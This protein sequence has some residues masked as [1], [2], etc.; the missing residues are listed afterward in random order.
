[1]KLPGQGTKEAGWLQL[2]ESHDGHKPLSLVLFL[3]SQNTRFK[4]LVN[5]KRFPSVVCGLHHS[6]SCRGEEAVGKEEL[7]LHPISWCPWDPTVSLPWVLHFLL[8]CPGVGAILSF[9]PLFSH[10]MTQ[11]IFR[12]DSCIKKHK[13]NSRKIKGW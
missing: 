4:M 6:L 11:R 8:L 1:M 13:E 7:C 3:D 12:E 9:A 2:G 10:G 5:V